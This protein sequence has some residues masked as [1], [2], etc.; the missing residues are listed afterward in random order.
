MKKHPLFHQGC[1]RARPSSLSPCPGLDH[2][3]PIATLNQVPLLVPG[4]SYPLETFV[5]S[6]SDKGVT[7]VIKVGSHKEGGET[8]SGR[9]LG[10][11]A[12]PNPL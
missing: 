4:L 7:D 8:R 3:L 12:L 11:M 9:G 6:L 5:E 2:T 1:D 10:P